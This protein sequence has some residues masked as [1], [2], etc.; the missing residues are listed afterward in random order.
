MVRLLRSGLVGIIALSGILL[1]ATASAIASSD[2]IIG[3][4]DKIKIISGVNIPEA[5]LLPG[6]NND[7]VINI[8]I[9]NEGDKIESSL[10]YGVILYQPKENGGKAVDEVYANESFSLA[11]GE[12]VI[13]QITYTP[14][15][16]FKGNYTIGASVVNTSGLL[17]A[18]ASVGAITLENTGGALYIDTAKC[19]VKIVGV[20][21]SY[22]LTHG[23][24]IASAESIYAECPVENQSA[25]DID[26]QIQANIHD[27]SHAGKVVETQ[28]FDVESIES[29]STKIMRFNVPKIDRAQAYSARFDLLSEE[30]MISNPVLMHFVVQGPSANV[31]HVRFDK[32][33]YSKGDTAVVTVSIASR[34]D[35]FQNSRY[36]KAMQDRTEISKLTYDVTTQIEGCSKAVKTSMGH[37]SEIGHTHEIPVPIDKKCKNPQVSVTIEDT[38]GGTLDKKMFAAEKSDGSTS[39]N[40]VNN[41]LPANTEESTKADHKSVKPIAMIVI[42]GSILLAVIILLLGKKKKNTV[43]AL[44]GIAIGGTLLLSAPQSAQALSIDA[45]LKGSNGQ[46]IYTYSVIGSCNP[47]ITGT[48]GQ[49]GCGNKPN[50]ICSVVKIDESD[51]ADFDGD[52]SNALVEA[53]LPNGDKDGSHSAK[54]SLLTWGHCEYD[55]SSP[56]YGPDRTDKSVEYTVSCGTPSKCTYKLSD[57]KYVSS[58]PSSAK[59]TNDGIPK[60]EKYDPA[61]GAWTWQCAPA[62]GTSPWDGNCG[63]YKV[64]TV[65]KCGPSNGTKPITS[66]PIAGTK[67]ACTRGTFSDL[68][69]DTDG[70]SPT[71][72]KFNWE[73]LGSDG[74][75][76]SCSAPNQ[77]YV[78]PTK[79]VCGTAS[80][81]EFSH[82]PT[83]NRCE[84]GS[85]V[86]SI[87]DGGYSWYCKGA[88]EGPLS[89]Q[90]VAKKPSVTPLCGPAD[91]QS[92]LFVAPNDADLCGPGLTAVKENFGDPTAAKWIWRCQ[93][94]AGDLSTQCNAAKNCVADNQYACNGKCATISI[95]GEDTVNFSRDGSPVKTSQKVIATD[96]SC[97]E[98]C[99]IDGQSVPLSS[100]NTD[101]YELEVTHSPAGDKKITKCILR[102]PTEC[103]EVLHDPNDPDCKKPE[104][105]EEKTVQCVCVAR[106][107][108]DAGKCVSTRVFG[109]SGPTDSACVDDCSDCQDAYAEEV[110]P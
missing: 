20:E 78:T 102:E 14:P 55:P 83:T 71:P 16:A 108:S 68:P 85:T 73:C 46:A 11:P 4:N 52:Q 3:S 2:K 65:G 94:A 84:A 79:G 26:F 56:L 107:C 5:N 98:S 40:T 80:G 17:L 9:R 101:V 41:N 91:T 37:G 15:H 19:A 57:N 72:T 74:D 42:I 8:T 12:T 51:I 24:D 23:I 35:T 36:E 30:E 77:D 63:A 7:Y 13:K 109:A 81:A 100:V 33:S 67:A 54:L 45:G 10:N 97:I 28:R 27:R 86:V 47:K 110:Q 87:A 105:E 60:D 29:E 93:N 53:S 95:E 34:A 99:I 75:N 59:C 92:H 82:P 106:Q 39:Q 48:L 103:G 62:T 32:E 25:N 6:E 1:F 96:P 38:S 66:N 70:I 69:N 43:N 61:T 104:V 89:P 21:E 88:G 44:L 76:D 49:W 64:K 22:T 18:P 90:C 50:D 58:M 31:Q